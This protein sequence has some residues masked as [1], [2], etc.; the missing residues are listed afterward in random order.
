MAIMLLIL[1][2]QKLKLLLNLLKI[3]YEILTN[4]THKFLNLATKILSTKNNF[5]VF[6]Y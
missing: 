2:K 6:L 5:L 1:C 4:L 3:F